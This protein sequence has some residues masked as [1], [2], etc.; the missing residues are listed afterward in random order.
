MLKKQD[1]HLLL[2]E[3]SSRSPNNFDVSYSSWKQC[4]FIRKNT[5]YFKIIIYY[6][7]PYLTMQ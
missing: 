5:Y 4:E 3:S 6:V 1:N 2:H 7:T